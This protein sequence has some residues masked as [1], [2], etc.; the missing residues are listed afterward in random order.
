MNAPAP[1]TEA[2]VAA[3]RNKLQLAGAA[4]LSDFTIRQ[5]LE[6]AAAVSA[7]TPTVQGEADSDAAPT[8]LQAVEALVTALAASRGWMRDYARAVIQDAID[9][10]VTKQTPYGPALSESHAQLAK[11]Y[12]VDSLA[13]LVDMQ[14]HHIE[15]LQ[16]KL[17]QSP[18][19][20]AP[21]RVR[22]G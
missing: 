12:G 3:A 14:A 9:R 22:E 13:A 6:S 19:V 4:F 16:A 1:V 8:E 10:T 20:F 18:N 5:V 2:M 17:P 11:F 15:K 7:P 21:Q